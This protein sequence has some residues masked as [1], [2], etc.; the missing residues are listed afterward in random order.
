MHSHGD[1]ASSI[2]AREHWE[3]FY[4]GKRPWSGKPNAILVEEI[5]DI[6]AD[7][8]G[9]LDL[10]CGS[11]VLAIAVAKSL[12]HARIVAAVRAEQR[13]VAALAR[14]G[15]HQV[16]LLGELRAVGHEVVAVAQFPAAAERF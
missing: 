12:P 5:G 1:P 15:G 11:G 16:A 8:K 2:D 10:G 3:E 9:A 7:G 6:D 4:D 14:V 13:T